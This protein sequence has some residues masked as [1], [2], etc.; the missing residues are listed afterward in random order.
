[1]ICFLNQITTNFYFLLA[2]NFETIGEPNL[3]KTLSYLTFLNQSSWIDLIPERQAQIDFGFCGFY[4]RFFSH[5][6][7]EIIVLNTNLYYNANITE[8]DPCSQ[9]QHTVYPRLIR[10]HTRIY[11]Y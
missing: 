4:T 2:N 7:L 10:T 5:L 11:F 1:M 8:T 9:V 6:N 3:Y